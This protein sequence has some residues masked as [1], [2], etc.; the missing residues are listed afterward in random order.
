[1]MDPISLLVRFALGERLE[2]SRPEDRR[3]GAASLLGIAVMLSILILAEK[4]YRPVVEK[5]GNLGAL[6]LWAMA[7]FGMSALVF[8]MY[9]WMRHVPQRVTITLAV[10]V[11]VLLLWM[12][13]G[14]GWW[15]FG[16]K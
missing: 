16:R 10:L 6:R 1:M 7:V 12:L 9:Y 5:I 8:A 15:D 4:Y 2:K 14:L 13:F 11:W 3:W